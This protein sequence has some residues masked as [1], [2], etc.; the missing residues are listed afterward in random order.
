MNGWMD[1]EP[2]TRTLIRDKRTDQQRRCLT[3]KHLFV[4]CYV[5]M[6]SSISPERWN[7]HYTTG[8]RMDG[9][10]GGWMDGW[11]DDKSRE[12]EKDK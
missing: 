1:G 7:E 4:L 12:K 8:R 11:L 2:S 9:W 6:L 3:A 10:I 5:Y